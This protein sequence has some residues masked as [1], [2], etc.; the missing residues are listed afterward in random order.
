MAATCGIMLSLDTGRSRLVGYIGHI[1]LSRHWAYSS[2]EHMNFVKRKVTTAI[3]NYITDD[4][5]Q[6]NK[7]LWYSNCSS[8]D[9]RNSY[10]IELVLNFDQ[11][12]IRI[13]PVSSWAVDK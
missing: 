10:S 6:V 2:L 4:F 8:S 1:E 3:S 7:S 11:T 12:G 13:V 9:E 5:K